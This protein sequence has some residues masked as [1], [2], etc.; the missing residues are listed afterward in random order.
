VKKKGCYF[1]SRPRR[2]G[3]SLFLGALYE[4]L[5][6]NRSLFEGLWIGSSGY[7]F[8]KY[9]IVRLN[10]VGSCD[11]AEVLKKTIIGKLKNS[12]FKS[13]IDNF[14]IDTPDGVLEELVNKLNRQTGERVAVLIDEYDAPILAMI[15]N[16][17]Q[18]LANRGVLQSFY[19]ALK[20]LVDQGMISYVFVTGVTKF[21]KTSIFSVFNNLYDL[22]LNPGFNAVCGFTLE[23]FE[24]Y[25]QEYLPIVLD[26]NKANGFMPADA[27]LADLKNEILGYYDGYSWNGEERLLNSFS[28]IQMLSEKEFQSY[29]FSTGTPTFL[30]D[31]LKRDGGK[32]DLPD[33]AEMTRDELDAADVENLKLIPIMFQTGYLTIDKRLGPRA[34]LLRR[35]NTEVSE[36]L[37]RNILGYLLGQGQESITRL[38]ERI[39]NALENHDSGELSDCF[40]QILTWTSHVEH[41]A[42]EGNYLGL[43]GSVL[44][45][46]HFT[47]L[48]QLNESEGVMDFMVTLGKK[49]AFI[50]EFKYEK[51]DSDPKSDRTQEEM[52]ADRLGL[53]SRALERAKRQIAFRKYDEKYQYEYGTVKKVAVAIV[54]KTDVAVEIY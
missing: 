16:K 17:E 4:L 9:P 23:E 27:T 18:A 20:S 8:K 28:L 12:A 14:W 2:F 13:G 30:L 51:F 7:D 39:G 31:F 34:Y 52:D 15:G 22:T 40:H 6:G 37:S 54:G 32:F 50:F 38:R 42:V 11:S 26:H 53:L 48:F 24:S 10:M 36:A 49:A 46:M 21:A 25:F 45:A 44:K 35:P 33:K 29:W 5:S 3:K 47:A 19:S 1:L 41:R 43:L